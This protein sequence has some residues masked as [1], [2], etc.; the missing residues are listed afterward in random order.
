MKLPN[1][2]YQNVPLTSNAKSCKCKLTALFIV[3]YML[4]FRIF[5]LDTIG[6][7]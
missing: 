3:A 2:I 1:L 5:S 7:C 4:L 6:L